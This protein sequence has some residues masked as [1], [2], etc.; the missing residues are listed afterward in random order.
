MPDTRFA[1]FRTPIATTPQPK[2]VVVI[3][4]EDSL[5]HFFPLPSRDY[6]GRPGIAGQASSPLWIGTK[7]S[8]MPGPKYNSISVTQGIIFKISVNIIPG[9]LSVR[10]SETGSRSW[11]LTGDPSR[12]LMFTRPS[13]F[14]ETEYQVLPTS[15]V[16]FRIRRHNP[17]PQAMLGHRIGRSASITSRPLPTNSPLVI[18]RWPDRPAVNRASAGETKSG[19]SG[20]GVEHVRPPRFERGTSRSTVDCS[21]SLS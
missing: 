16:R 10:N 9:L 14:L 7:S 1:L 8:D 20:P 17:T 3:K 11:L 18:L 4:R 12:E 13:V 6:R 5:R 21:T 2:G 19:G 15:S